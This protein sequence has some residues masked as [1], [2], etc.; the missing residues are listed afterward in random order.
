M[1][2]PSH[3]VAEDEI[4]WE[5]GDHERFQARTKGLSKQADCHRLGCR[6]V[7]V[8]PGSAAWPFHY[9]IAVEEVCATGSVSDRA[10]LFASALP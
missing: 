4:D 2:I 7:E 6:L 3:K 5:Q 8:P 1:A 9:H 10:S